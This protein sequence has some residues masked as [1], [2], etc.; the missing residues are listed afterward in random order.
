MIPL[1]PGRPRVVILGAGFGGLAAAH[2][3]RRAPVQVTL[4]DRNN[5]H[6]FQPL[7]Y[8]A[9]TSQLDL[10]DVG[11]PLRTILRRHKNTRVLMGVAETVDVDA[12]TV[13][14]ETG[15]PLGY[16][17]LIVATGV[18][19]SYFAHPEWRAHAPGL[20]SLRD[21][22]EVRTRV[23]VAFERA[24]QESD[25]GE[26][27]ASLT[28][29]VVGGGPTG[30]ELAG[31]IAELSRHALKRDFQR[32]A[33]A[34]ARVVLVEAGPAILRSY[35]PDLQVKAVKQLVA[36]G[37]EVRP[38]TRVLDVDEHG[39][40][41]G[42]ETIAARTVLWAAG[43]AGTAIARSLGVPLDRYG[44]VPVTPTLNP[45]GLA[46]VFVIGD[47]AA[48]AQDGQAVPGVAPAAIQ[49]GRYVAR[50]IVEGLRGEP[51]KPFRY[52]DKGQ[53]ATIGRSRAVAVLGRNIRVSGF[54]AWLIYSTVHLIYIIEHRTRIRV[55]LTWVWSFLTYARGAR[56]IASMDLVESW[57]REAR[58]LPPQELERPPSPPP[59]GHH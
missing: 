2:A 13:R 43:M 29:V 55:L 25:P 45:P 31:A 28:F 19:S 22:L 14:L 5:H 34:K 36:L 21:A 12:Q 15:E 51:I 1:P 42:D 44:L 8:Q 18:E 58:Q 48:L 26:Q 53:L 50:A 10:P 38:A 6:V 49:E 23:L 20:K 41:L 46:N 32:I 24:E 17:Y 9:A 59:P 27:A 57:R 39:V 4:V 16:D 37:V 11:Y 35:P 7:L 47:L 30:V 40:R 3:L 52:F 54:L 56:L 33:P